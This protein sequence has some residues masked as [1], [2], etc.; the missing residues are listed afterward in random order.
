MSTF[1]DGLIGFYFA[2]KHRADESE[3]TD[4]GL[5]AI[6]SFRKWVTSSEWNFANKLY[7]LEAEYYYLKEDHERAMSC[8][9][10]SLM[11]AREHRFIHEEGLAEEKTATYLLHT[12]RHDEAMVRFMKAKNCDEVWGARALLQRV[13]K[14]IAILLPLCSSAS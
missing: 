10:A 5:A 2:R 6:R 4:V 3:W 8:Y 7:L 14:A 13:D 1:I 9:N 11:A 12:G